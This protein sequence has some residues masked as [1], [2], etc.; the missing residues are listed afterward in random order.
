MK[1]LGERHLT[2]D[3]AVFDGAM[4]QTYV[5]ETLDWL[6]ELRNALEISVAKIS[7]VED[8]QFISNEESRFLQ[9]WEAEKLRKKM[10]L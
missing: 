8:I 5:P 6:R 10:N 7:R 2:P 9:Q 4:S 1:Y 3:H